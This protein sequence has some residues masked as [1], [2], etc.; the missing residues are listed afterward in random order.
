MKRPV[1]MRN[2][3]YVGIVAIILPTCV[4]GVAIAS[5][6][7]VT[8]GLITAL[9][10]TDITL[11]G[12]SVTSWNDQSGSLNHALQATADS[13][14]VL[15]IGV[16]PKGGAAVSFDGVDDFLDI[17]PNPTDFDSTGFTWYI[18][19]QRDSTSESRMFTS[20]YADIDSLTPGDQYSGQAWGSYAGTLERH[21]AVVRDI[22]NG[23]NVANTSPMVTG[24]FYVTGAT[25]DTTSSTENLTAVLLAGLGDRVSGTADVIDS[26]ELSGHLRTRIGA[27]ASYNDPFAIETPI[28]KYD[29]QIAEILVYNR[30]LSAAEQT[31]VENYLHAKHIGYGP[32]VRTWLPSDSAVWGDRA[33]W[34]DPFFGAPSNN[35]LTAVFGDSI[36][37]SDKTVAVDADVTIN[38]ITVNNPSGGSYVIG[39]LGSITFA[40]TDAL[41]DPSVSVSQGNHQIQAPIVIDA[42]LTVSVA[43]GSLDFG[44]EIDLG[45]NTMTISGSADIN[46]SVI[47]GGTIVNGGTLGTQG[48]TSIVGSLSSTGSLQ[49]DLGENNVDLFDLTGAASLSGTLDVVLE[50]SFTPSGSYTVVSSATSLNAAGLSLAAE[51][52]AMF[53]L[54]VQGNDLLLVVMAIENADF[55]SDMDVDLADLMAWQRGFG[56]TSGA[57]LS[58]GDANGDGAVDGDDLAIWKNQ[59]GEVH[60]QEA[61]STAVP[62]PTSMFLLFAASVGVLMN[63]FKKNA[64]AAL[65]VALCLLGLTLGDANTA[66]A[67]LPTT[68]LITQLDAAAGITESGGFVSA[69]ADQSGS[70]NSALQSTG[71]SQPLLVTGVTPAGTPAID[72][73]GTDFMDIGSSSDFLTNQL[74]W[75]VVFNTRRTG[76][77]DHMIS[78][79]YDDVQ[80]DAG[81]QGTG[82]SWGTL[83]QTDNSLNALVRDNDSPNPGWHTASSSPGDVAV[84][85]FYIAVATWDGTNSTSDNIRSILIDDTGAVISDTTGASYDAEDSNPTWLSHFGTRIGGA[86]DYNEL[87]ASPPAALEYAFHGQIAEVLIYDTQLTGTDLTDVQD[88]LVTKH[89][90]GLE[91]S[92]FYWNTADSGDWNAAA[93]WT[94][95]FY[96]PPNSNNKGVELGDAIGSSTRTVFLDSPA[97]INGLDFN[98]TLGGSYALSG[99]AGLTLAESS[100]LDA[101]AITVTSGDHQIQTTLTLAADA[102]IDAS[103]GTLDINNEIDLAGNT[104]TLSGSVVINGAIVGGGT[105][106]NSGALAAMGGGL[107]GGDLLNDGTLIINGSETLTVAGDAT[108]SGILDVEFGE[109]AAAPLKI[110]TAGGTLDADSIVLDASDAGAYRLLV[111]GNSLLLVAIPEPG[112]AFLAC[113]GVLTLLGSL[114]RRRA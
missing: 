57:G 26:A 89:I 83:V 99:H 32:D 36:G 35:N 93:N 18:V 19:H 12:S 20:C 74:S 43:S 39:G 76:N 2:T 14:P 110:L 41:A 100:T 52:E 37:S 24:N 109:E 4:C 34:T 22:G 56:I 5:L 103:G 61:A 69:W 8:T 51:D 30:V 66:R 53:D 59:L 68:G 9:D 13:Q 78:G 49:I 106:I 102:S 65:L 38:G 44:N 3:V 91:P 113:Y 54:L 58:D 73:D 33:N 96:A 104:L 60:T 105:V 48:T 46:H 7:P 107:I 1:A 92:T 6:P 15:V 72:F 63:R 88:Y 84:N 85:R 23:F 17:F 50:A 81:N 42:D 62:E 47:G 71:D 114:R 87:P 16:T 97:T 40:A 64:P 27:S 112:T 82:Q 21:R 29:G 55:D 77:R 90:A 10:T 28:S 25:W 67:D 98:N 11:D 75:C 108:L 94:S 79:M 86:A 70:G 45:G 111:E 80:P 95:A 101:P 31:S